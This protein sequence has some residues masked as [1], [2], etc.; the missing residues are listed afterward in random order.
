MVDVDKWVCA[1]ELGRYVVITFDAVSRE[2]A[3]ELT[4]AMK[5]SLLDA[6]LVTE[7]DQ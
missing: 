5:K 3:T 4:D 6:N 1:T 2:S 7:G